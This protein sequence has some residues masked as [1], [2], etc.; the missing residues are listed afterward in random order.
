MSIAL[1]KRADDTLLAWE[2]ISERLAIARFKS[3]ITN[4]SVIA[5]YAKTLNSEESSKDDF[6]ARLQ[7]IV[8]RIPLSDVL[9]AADDWNARTGPADEWTLE[10]KMAADKDMKIFKKLVNI[11]LYNRLVATNSF[12]TPTVI[13]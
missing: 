7:A 5:M 1:N 6:Y 13:Y 11:L 12:S 4:I 10:K 9:L 2:P 8:D 3:G